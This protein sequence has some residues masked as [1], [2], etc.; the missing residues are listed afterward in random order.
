MMLRISHPHSAVP[1]P[2]I[3]KRINSVKIHI[4]REDG[5]RVTSGPGRRD[6]R[7]KHLTQ[8]AFHPSRALRATCN[9]LTN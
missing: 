2:Y 8:K 4:G 3:Q 7:Q 6:V 1:G 9:T 5:L